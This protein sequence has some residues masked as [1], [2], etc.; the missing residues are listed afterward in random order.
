MPTRIG[1]RSVAGRGYARSDYAGS[2][3]G[4]LIEHWMIEGTDHAWSGGR[5][6]GSFT[7]KQGPDASAHMIRFFMVKPA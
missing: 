7:E 2:D 3:G 5:A 6:A 1:K 4:T